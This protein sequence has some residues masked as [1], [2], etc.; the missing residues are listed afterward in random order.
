MI[1]YDY[2]SNMQF[3]NEVEKEGYIMKI[4]NAWEIQKT[5]KIKT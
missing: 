5:D 4:P 2:F 1:N 3:T